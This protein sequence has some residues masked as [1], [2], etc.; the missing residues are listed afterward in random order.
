M[1]HKN[2]PLFDV[3]PEGLTLAGNLMAKRRQDGAFFIHAQQLTKTLASAY[4]NDIITPHT[5]RYLNRAGELMA[6]VQDADWDA[7]TPHDM[8]H[9]PALAQVRMLLAL[10]TP[11]PL[12]K[13]SP[14]QPRIPAGNRNGGQWTNEGDSSTA[15]SDHNGE[16]Q[17]A[18]SN[19]I[20]TDTTVDNSNNKSLVKPTSVKLDDGT[21]VIDPT[22][23]K[24]ILM[25]ADVSLNDNAKWGE[26]LSNSYLRSGHM[27][28]AF[29]PDGSMDYQRTYSNQSDKNGNPLINRN[30]IDFGNFNYGVVGAA[31]GYSLS[32]LLNAAA[33][34]NSRNVFSSRTNIVT[35]PFDTS[36]EKP[37]LSNP[38][39]DKFIIMGYNAYINGKIKASK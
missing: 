32:E 7:Q 9:I 15:A 17:V 3:T 13:Y 5:I 29:M 33:T 8:H 14:E 4:G 21:T 38:R 19:Q 23:G 35:N 27:F 18:D 34:I 6:K 25:P 12:Y 26:E 20:M 28:A 11:I 39:N 22:T 30:Y 2:L 10:A 31:A 24:P 36:L 1:Q 37:W 16:Y